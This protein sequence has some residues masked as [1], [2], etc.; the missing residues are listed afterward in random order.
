MRVYLKTENT[1]TIAQGYTAPDSL[2]LVP[3][4]IPKIENQWLNDGFW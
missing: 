2:N 1:Q 3:V 4:L